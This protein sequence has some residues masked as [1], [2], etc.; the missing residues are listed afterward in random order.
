MSDRN[1]KKYTNDEVQKELNDRKTI[2]EKYKRYNNFMVFMSIFISMSVL[3]TIMLLFDYQVLKPQDERTNDFF[4]EKSA[5][6]SFELATLLNCEEA[7][8]SDMEYF[9]EMDK[10]L[11]EKGIH[12]FIV[13]EG[14]VIFTSEYFDINKLNQDMKYSLDDYREN[15]IIEKH[16]I[17]ESGYTIYFLLP[18]SDAMLFKNSFLIFI[19]TIFLIAT[20]FRSGFSHSIMKRIYQNMVSPLEK[21][22][23]ATN[24]IRKGNLD[25]PL[26]PE[27]HYN[28]D[29]KETFQDFE[30][31]RE[32]LKENKALAVQYEN[33]RKDLIS[34]ISHDLKTPIASIMGYVEGILD[35]VADTPAKR[36]RYMQIIYKKSLDMNRLVNDLILF[37]KLDVN[38]VAFNYQL[39]NFQTYIETLFEE[40]GM[41]MQ[42]NNIE[43]VSR[44][45]ATEDMMLKVDAK[46]LRRVFNNIIG[47]AMKHL[48]KETK[49]V[50]IVVY[51][52]LDDVV[53]RISDNGKGIPKDKVDFI[54]DRF[55]KGEVSRNTEVGSSGLGLSISKQIVL[56]HGGRIWAQSEI[57][58]GTIIYF[59]ISKKEENY[60]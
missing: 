18:K 37:S 41:E 2:Q 23:D 32:Q 31:M 50:E 21:L 54:F 16:R 15:F 9:S 45:Q 14:H 7:D 51:E 6:I 28:R 30:K 57:G 29:L 22:K 38:K 36:E 4:T 13:T 47:N 58:K 33:N 56:A 43:L 1:L 5:I 34:N 27:Y 35:G 24:N 48:D 3:M 19:A 26:V 49:A 8:L 42:E 52:D 60:G 46:Q 59:T 44:Y 55:Y 11:S 40:Y 39:I 10:R 53:I 20:I 12:M 25:V 17:P